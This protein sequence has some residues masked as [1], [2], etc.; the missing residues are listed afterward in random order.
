MPGLATYG[1]RSSSLASPVA[2]PAPLHVARAYSRGDELSGTSPAE[3]LPDLPLRLPDREPLRFDPLD[4]HR[5]IAP[6]LSPWS[7]Q[8]TAFPMPNFLRSADLRLS[9]REKE[10][11]QRLL[12]FLARQARLYSVPVT[13]VDVYIFGD[14]EERSQRVV[15][16][17]WV[18]LT[19]DQALTYWNALAYL[20][21]EWAS[22]LPPP[23]MLIARERI[24]LEVRWKRGRD[25]I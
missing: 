2:S 10:A 15:V 25:V 5:S 21:Y 24:D 12:R 14:P 11:L 23:L 7:L 20:V 13:K 4:R 17:Q 3:D 19:S 8:A 18:D 6:P 9:N 1:N 16:T 22:L